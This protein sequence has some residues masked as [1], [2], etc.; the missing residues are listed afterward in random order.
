MNQLASLMKSGVVK[1]IA[2]GLGISILVPL[3]ANLLAPI[4]RPLARGAL[5]AGV[6]AYERGRE[7]IAE[8]GEVVEDLAAEVREDLQ[9]TRERKTLAVGSGPATRGV[10]QRH[11][12][13]HR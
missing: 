11:G 9:K 7:T 12:E 1:N 2:I 6:I 13:D 10:A 8:I 5:K 4:V 3:A